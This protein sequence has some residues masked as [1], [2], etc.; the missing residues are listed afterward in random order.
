MRG[1]AASLSRAGRNSRGPE[2][3]CLIDTRDAVGNPGSACS[4]AMLF[5]ASVVAITINTSEIVTWPTIS[6]L[7]NREP[8]TPLP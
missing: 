8:D 2:V 3:R 1:S 7:R 4:I 5:R 6:R